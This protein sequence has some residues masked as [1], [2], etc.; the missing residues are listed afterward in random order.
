MAR[1]IIGGA[2]KA[3]HKLVQADENTIVI[4]RM[5]DQA[6]NIGRGPGMECIGYATVF[7]YRSKFNTDGEMRCH[8]EVKLLGEGS[9]ND[10]YKSLGRHLMQQFGRTPSLEG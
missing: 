6:G 1:Q 2:K 3:T 5:L 8:A 4:R 9:T 10:G 7:Y